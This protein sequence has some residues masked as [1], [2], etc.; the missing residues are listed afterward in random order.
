MHNRENLCQKGDGRAKQRQ[1]AIE[2]IYTIFLMGGRGVFKV[3]TVGF[4]PTAG[5]FNTTPWSQCRQ[6]INTLW[7]QRNNGEYLG[8][9]I[10]LFAKHLVLASQNKETLGRDV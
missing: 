1:I 10:L 5:F 8:E 4:A 7:C 9:F 6:G 3:L 2:E